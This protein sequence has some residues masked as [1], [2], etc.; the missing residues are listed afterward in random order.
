MSERHFP[1][2]WQ[3]M[4][5]AGTDRTGDWLLSLE[6]EAMAHRQMILQLAALL[7]TTTLV[8]HPAPIVAEVY[9][10]MSEPKPGDWVAEASAAIRAKFGK[11]AETWY[12][13]FGVLLATRDEAASTD[14]QWADDLRTWGAGAYDGRGERVHEDAW[15]VQY[16]PAPVDIC[17]WGNCTFYALPVGEDFEALQ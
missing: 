2:P 6:E 12:Q 14:E 5:G 11:P 17:R 13:G 1:Q 7:R 16:G 8:G 10:R 15:Y 4:H 3:G 9:R